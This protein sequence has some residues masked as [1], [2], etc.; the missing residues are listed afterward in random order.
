MTNLKPHLIRAIYDWITVNLERPYIVV[1]TLYPDVI[2]PKDYINSDNRIT[3]DISPNIRGV[4][5]AIDTSWDDEVLSFTSNFSGRSTYI[6]IPIEAIVAIYTKST[7][8]GM[9]FDDVTLVGR[10]EVPAISTIRSATE[11]S[12]VSSA[13]GKPKLTIV[14][15]KETPQ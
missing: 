8:A 1:N 7:G 10:E 11:I 2:V 12:T 4:G 9:V 5:A 13:K 3:L 6:E 15:K 14:K